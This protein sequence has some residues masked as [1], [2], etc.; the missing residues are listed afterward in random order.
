MN[1]TI[2]EPEATTSVPASPSPDDAI[3]A[4]GETR[5]RPWM[6]WLAIPG[7]L[8]LFVGG[9]Y[10]GMLAARFVC[11]FVVPSWIPSHFEGGNWGRTLRTAM[12]LPRVA[13]LVIVLTNACIVLLVLLVGRASG[14][15]WRERLG[16]TS[17]CVPAREFPVLVLASIGAL[18]IGWV[19]MTELRSAGL[20]HDVAASRKTLASALASGSPAAK[21]LFVFGGSVLT[22][23]AEELVFRGYLQRALLAHWR[24]VLAVGVAPV[25]AIGVA[26]VIFAAMHG[27]AYDV[28]VLPVAVFLGYLAWRADSI[29]PTIV[30]HIMVNGLGQSAIAIWG[31]GSLHHARGVAG[32]GLTPLQS[33]AMSVAVLIGSAFLVWI[34]VSRV[35]R[36]AGRTSQEA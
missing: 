11:T 8:L 35:E 2:R 26:S 18:G 16:L 23:I 27:V 21:I 14:R 20:L 28:Y 32:S 30:C 10:L 5:S 4:G 15:R 24:P 9:Q 36:S 1:P 12:G 3:A 33:G 31:F 29:F 7:A 22:G 17:G 34:G 6:G 25:L 19:V 13:A